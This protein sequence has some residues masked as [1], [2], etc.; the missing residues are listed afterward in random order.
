MIEAE[1][2]RAY[3]AGVDVR[4]RTGLARVVAEGVDCLARLDIVAANAS[5]CTVQPH[6]D[7]TATVWQTTIDGQLDGCLAYVAPA[8]RTAEVRRNT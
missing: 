6:E 3:A 8:P 2:R 5:I 1:G 4:D 7:V